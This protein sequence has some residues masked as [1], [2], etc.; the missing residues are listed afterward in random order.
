MKNE[1]TS[2]VVSCLPFAVNATRNIMSLGR[3]CQNSAE[4]IQ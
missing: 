3:T 1:V 4:N 2:D